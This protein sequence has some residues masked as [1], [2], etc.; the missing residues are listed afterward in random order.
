MKKLLLGALLSLSLLMSAQEEKGV[1]TEK[2]TKF[3]ITTDDVAG[4]VQYSNITVV[5]NEN[6]TN[7]IGIYLSDSKMLLYSSGKI[8]KGKTTSG[9]EYQLVKCIVKDSGKLV[10]LQLFADVLRIFTNEAY[11]DSIQFFN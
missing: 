3:I 11:T 10:A 8:E 1:F 5:Y 7:D 2:Y 9:M 4:K 6:D